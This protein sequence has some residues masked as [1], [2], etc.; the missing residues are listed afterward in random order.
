MKLDYLDIPRPLFLAPMHDVTDSP[1]RS[2][3]RSL[4]A[5]VVVSEFVSAEAVIRRVSKAFD[6]LRFNEEER[7]IGLQIFGARDESMSEA[8]AIISELRPDFIDINCGCWNKKHAMRGECAGL[9]RDLPQMERILRA[10][11]KATKIPITVKTRLGWDERSLNILDVSKIVQD[12]GVRALTV[13]CRTR[14]QGYK[15]KAQW[16]WLEKIKNRLNIPLIGNGDVV[17]P[18][19][20][21]ELFDS[22]CDGVMIGRGALADP[23]IFHKI[24][25][26]FLPN[27]TPPLALDLSSKADLCVKHLKLTVER[28]GEREGLIRFRKFYAGYF[29]DIP[30]G[31]KL[32]KSFYACLETDEIQTKIR[33][34]LR[35]FRQEIQQHQP[36]LNK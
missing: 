13:H 10:C 19:D 7:P 30:G 34:F 1:F 11:V 6:L 18:A 12:C 36:Y 8:V 24:K 23:W 20:A 29:H 14:C 28:Y 32:R 31:A 16:H 35:D 25:S 22:G 15:G 33:E 3:C 9:L 21:Q 27:E 4:G 17:G 5:D 2:V 26:T